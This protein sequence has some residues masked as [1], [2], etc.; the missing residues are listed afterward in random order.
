MSEPAAEEWKAAYR[1]GV[2]GRNERWTR[3]PRESPPLSDA[4]LEHLDYLDGIIAD[5]KDLDTAGSEQRISR[6]VRKRSS[7]V[8]R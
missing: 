4:F 6:A 5:I 7:H 8:V 2:E 3:P 1:K